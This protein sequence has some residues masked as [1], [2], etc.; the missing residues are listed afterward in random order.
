MENVE[1]QNP[2]ATPKSPANQQEA[3]QISR[4]NECLWMGIIS[5]GGTIVAYGLPYCFEEFTTGSVVVTMF[6]MLLHVIAAIAGGAGIAVGG[7]EA[8][9]QLCSKTIFG[10]K[11]TVFIGVALS[12]S[13]I[14]I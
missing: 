4:S 1:T 5:A 13:L 10:Q 14:H 3:N 11:E 8:I 6:A 9:A 2:F 12:L 7:I